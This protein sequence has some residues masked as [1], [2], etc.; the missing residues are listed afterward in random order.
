MEEGKVEPKKGYIHCANLHKFNVCNGGFLFS[1]HESRGGA[2][3]T[4]YHGLNAPV[5]EATEKSLWAAMM[6][7][8]E[9]HAL[10]ITENGQLDT[11]KLLLKLEK[12]GGE[13]LKVKYLGP[14][15]ELM[16]AYHNE[17]GA[18]STLWLLRTKLA[19]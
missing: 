16:P 18:I 13:L 19:L 11:H 4:T 2:E 10:L 14:W 3:L 8:R 6:K 7:A 17:T 9:D 5:G 15:R 1:T 12:E